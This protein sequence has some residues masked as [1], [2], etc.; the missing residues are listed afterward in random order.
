MKVHRGKVHEYLGMT[1]DFNQKGLVKVS[2]TK[3]IDECLA[4]FE[5]MMPNAKG[6]K[7]CVAPKNLFEI[8]PEALKLPKE[9]QEQFHSLVAK[10]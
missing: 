6:T 2:M 4:T 8:D 10:V 7:E 5:K 1:L 9:K 3:Y